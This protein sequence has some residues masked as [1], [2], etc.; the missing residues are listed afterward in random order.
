MEKQAYKRYTPEEY[1]VFEE[2]AE[3]KSEYYQGDIFAMSGGS[4]N[5]NR[6]VMSLSSKLEASLGGSKCEAFMSDMRVWIEAKA[7]FT[8]P[9]ITIVCGDLQFYENRNDTITNPVVIF[10][11][12]SKSTE[13]YDRGKKFE[14]YRAIPALQEYILIDQYNMHIEQF[15]IGSE[16]K[17]VLT[18]YSNEKD[19]FQLFNVDFQMPLNEIYKRVDFNLPED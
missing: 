5:H 7:V 15:A 18:E 1:L 19:V 13:S 14:F 16:G 17:W 9:D 4:V 8:F 10:E 2:A 3:Y 6:I 12:L 11:V